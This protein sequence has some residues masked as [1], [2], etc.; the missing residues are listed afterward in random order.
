MI[1][2]QPSGSQAP[3]IT[4]PARVF[5]NIGYDHTLSWKSRRDARS[6]VGADWRRC[7][8]GSHFGREVRTGERQELIAASVHQHNQRDCKRV[9]ID[10][11]AQLLQ[12]LGEACPILNHFQCSL[13]HYAKQFFLLA[14]FNRNASSEPPRHGTRFIA[15]WCATDKKPMEDAVGAPQSDLAFTP[16]LSVARSPRV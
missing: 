16:L 12:D 3:I 5:R 10:G 7:K 15:Q 8:S 1:Q 4:R 11:S 9:F 2:N 14:V 6:H 13:L